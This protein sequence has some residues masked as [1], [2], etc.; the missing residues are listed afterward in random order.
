MPVSLE[1]VYDL[2]NRWDFGPETPD[3]IREQLRGE[4]VSGLKKEIQENYD[5]D[6]ILLRMGDDAFTKNGT[7][8]FLEP[9]FWYGDTKAAVIFDYLV[10]LSSIYLRTMEDR[11]AGS[12]K[13]VEIL[14]NGDRY[15]VLLGLIGEL[16]EKGR[17]AMVQKILKVSNRGDFN[18]HARDFFK[19]SVYDSSEV[20]KGDYQIQDIEKYSYLE[21]TL[22]PIFNQKEGELEIGSH[23]FTYTDD[24]GIEMYRLISET[25]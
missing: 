23:K 14:M 9:A 17:K 10:S 3:E 12:Q 18:K 8:N 5:V 15:L 22:A 4:I 7:Q 21:I 16:K 6:G 19:W 11:D 1:T 13:A 20:R 2:R 24:K 25:L